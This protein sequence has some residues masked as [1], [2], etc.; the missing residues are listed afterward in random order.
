MLDNVLIITAHSDDEVIGC[1]GAISYHL[2]KKD[3]VTCIYLT[4]GVSA[5]KDNKYQ[6]IPWN[7][8][9]I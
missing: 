2:K 8:H 3:R 6:I 5:R 7:F 1:G 9:R 4:D